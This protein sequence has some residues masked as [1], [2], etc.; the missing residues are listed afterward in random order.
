MANSNDPLKSKPWL[1]F[2]IFF[3]FVK[4]KA[5]IFTVIQL[6]GLYLCNEPTLQIHPQF[7]S[8]MWHLRCLQAQSLI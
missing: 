5:L 3:E 1:L 6:R 7:Y 8:E 2:F 4:Q